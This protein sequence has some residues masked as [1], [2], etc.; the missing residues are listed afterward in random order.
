[1]SLR[2]HQDT[3][4]ALHKRF[5]PHFFIPSHTPRW[6]LLACTLGLV[7]TIGV[8]TT[9]VQLVQHNSAQA[10]N[11][12]VP[13]SGTL[14]P[15]LKQSH[16]IGL[17][18]SQQRISLSLGLR[19]RNQAM[20]QAY[21]SGLSRPGSAIYRHFL[22]PAQ[23]A[24]LFSPTPAEYSAVQHYVQSQGFTVTG[25]YNH[26]LLLNF[27]G[28]VSQVEQVFHVT[29]RNYVAADK[30]V[31]YA[32]DTAPALPQ[33]LAP[34]VLSLTGLNNAARLSHP[35]V[36]SSSHSIMQSQ[37]CPPH[38]SN[39]IT[40]DQV[41]S[42][43]D[44]NGL[45]NNHMQ[46]E[47]QTIALFELDTFVMSDLTHYAACYGQSH[48]PVQT[49]VVGSNPVSTD[50]GVVEVELDAEMILS[51]AP[52]LGRLVIYEAANTDAGSLA[53]WAQIVQDAV[54]VVSTSWGQ[55]EALMN[56]QVA[57]E[58]NV[59]F[60]AAAVQ[61]QTI[62]AAAGDTGSADC[63][64]EDSTH[65]QVNA[66]DPAGQ[67][68]IV[69]VG[70]T[71]LLLSQSGGYGSETTWNDAPNVPPGYAGGA[72]GG[73]ISQFWQA[74][75]WQSAPG[76]HNS[77]SSGTPCN[78]SGQICREVPDVALN[79]SPLMGYPVYCTSLAAGC[80]SQ[81]NW[82]NVGGTSAA[83][84]LWAAILALA[85]QSAL[86]SGGLSLGFI[87]PLLYQIAS[88]N[89]MYAA[90]FHDVTTG[91]NDYNNYNSGAYPATADYD[92]ATG[93]GSCDATA[94][95]ANLV[96][97]ARAAQGQRISPAA[98]T[99]YFAEGSVGGG[100]QEYITL[101]NPSSTQGANVTITYLFENRPAVNVGHYVAASSRFTVNVNMDLGVAVNAPQQAVAAIVQV[102]AGGP[103]IVAE[104][105]MYFNYK[106]V[107][108]GTDVMGATS[109]GTSYYFPYADTR[110]SSTGPSYMSYITMLN[111]STTQTAHVTLTYYTGECGNS[112]Q[113]P[114]PT[115]Q[116]TIAPLHRGTGTPA[117]V[118]LYQQLA[119]SVQSD[120]PIVVERPMY[121]KDNIPSAGGSITGA[122]SVVG[123]TTPGQD[124]LFAEGYTGHNFQEYLVLAN[125]ASNAATATVK[126][127]YDNGHTQ[128]IAVNVPA[129][130][131]VMFNVNQANSAPYGTCDTTPCQVTATA[132]A[133]VTATAPIVVDRLMYFH[134][135]SNH[136]SGATEAVGEPGPAV[137]R[138][139]SFAEGYTA[140][141]F[142][143]YLTL[144]NPTQNDETVAVTLFFDTY[145][146]ETQYQVEAHSRLTVPINTLVAPIASAYNNLGTNSFSV[147]MTVQALG[148]NAVIVAE[149]P[150]YFNYHGD[151]GGTDVIGYTQPLT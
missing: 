18:N 2:P 86:H 23:Y 33:W 92:Q 105:P 91:T 64:R 81:T 126:L 14:T 16:E 67:P 123:A 140:N 69:A 120:Q 9:L 79:A 78:V 117:A 135:G 62:F 149:R 50:G 143:E 114:C 36:F 136:L 52:H 3:K 37:F 93:L 61:G 11:M 26:R 10:A 146:T 38:G 66:D 85:N 44:L 27:S 84:P 96:N 60:T 102:Q 21:M 41:A 75:A 145:V 22:T 97:L 74:P 132:S 99:W 48:T 95:A 8:G 129:F 139:F 7:L 73:G 56:P 53:E 19:P 133:E 106:G 24:A 6:L 141:S 77:Y 29:L 28:T 150:M 148:T 98:L 57:Q 108:S 5:L 51:A 90:S 35:P 82:F 137:Q 34:Q 112:S 94:L 55:C 83:A 89:T 72:G 119:A 70:G 71:R 43:Y 12:S 138:T 125:F 30:H 54:P 25:T 110:Q 100:F 88:N 39:Y 49:V 101:Q 122:A 17:T 1:M 115:Q 59:L 46:G 116:I 45:Y 15:L 131:H 107:P 40:P 147:S 121:F 104:R 58:E 134:F 31:Y 65:T 144:Q 118:Y 87:A 103:P 130:S 113:A 80:S 76:V 47:G 32:N 63:I 68:Y 4:E 142:V 20:L 111:P 151:Q 124:W 127:E 13:L 109:P 42:V 128:S